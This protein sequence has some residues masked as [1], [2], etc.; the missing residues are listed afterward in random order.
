M[1]PMMVETKAT[2]MISG[3]SVMSFAITAA[4]NCS[5]VPAPT[6]TVPAGLPQGTS[7]TGAPASDSAMMVNSDPSSH[8]SGRCA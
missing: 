3:N 2:A 7:R 6:T 8:G 5:P 1:A 4:V